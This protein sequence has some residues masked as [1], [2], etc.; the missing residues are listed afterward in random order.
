MG[1]AALVFLYANANLALKTKQ[2]FKNSELEGSR[3][4][5]F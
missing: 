5:G 1:V 4:V 2:A 3:F